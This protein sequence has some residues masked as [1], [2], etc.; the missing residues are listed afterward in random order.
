M[1]LPESE[2]TAAALRR[3]Q[4]LGLCRLGKGHG[5]TFVFDVSTPEGLRNAL[6]AAKSFAGPSFIR[7]SVDPRDL[8]RQLA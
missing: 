4:S 2:H 6:A 7:V 5:L 1:I 8:P 3:A